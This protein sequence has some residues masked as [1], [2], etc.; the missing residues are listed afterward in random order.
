MMKSTVCWVVIQK[1]PD[2]LETHI[3]SV[4]RVEE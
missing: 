3:A 2:V 1:E 4:F